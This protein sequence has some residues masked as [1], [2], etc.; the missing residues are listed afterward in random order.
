MFPLM[1]LAPTEYALRMRPI[2]VVLMVTLSVLIAG[3]FVIHDFWGAVN[4]LFVVLMGLFVLSGPFPINASS[5]PCYC[6]MASVS[7]VF[8]TISCVVYFH[9]SSYTFFDP[10][11]PKIVFLAQLIF[12]ASPLTL[13]VSAALSYSIFVDCRDNAQEIMPLAALARLEWEQQQLRQQQQPAPPPAQAQAQTPRS[14]PT[15][16]VPR[17]IVPFQGH[18]QRLGG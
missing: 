15:Q 17:L 18:G 7:G 9:H 16:A 13:L 14:Q 8:D 2:F 12:I 5:A 10:K 1:D 6:L 11:A 4:L 3:K